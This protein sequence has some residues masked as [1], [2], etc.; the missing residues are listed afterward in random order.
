MPTLSEDRD[1]IR[2][3]MARYCLYMDASRGDEFA[4]LFTEDA[5]FDT[6]MGDPVVGRAALSALATAMPAGAMH[7][8]F[9]NLVIDVDGDEAVC[10]ASAM[11]T[12]KGAIVMTAHTH[13]ELQRVD[14]EWLIKLR[15]FEPDPT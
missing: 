3:V 13:D 8:M 15:T 9:T 5:S 2:H 6:Q 14:G 1:A 10:D 7:H 11:V 12:S 4:S